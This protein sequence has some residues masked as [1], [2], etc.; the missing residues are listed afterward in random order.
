ML[1]GA[2][3]KVSP[4]DG[5]FKAHKSE[6][7][8]EYKSISDFWKMHIIITSPR[9]L[10]CRGGFNIF[11]LLFLKLKHKFKLLF[12]NRKAIFLRECRSAGV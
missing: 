4:L 6:S 9:I 7:S 2:L 3:L 12:G 5:R 11:T 10:K 8:N 1:V